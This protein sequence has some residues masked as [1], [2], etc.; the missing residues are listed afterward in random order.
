M[1]KQLIT[2]DSRK[3]SGRAR[4]E[5]GFSL[6]QLLITAMVMILVGAFALM[7][8]AS[9]RA[10]MRLAS[11]ARQ[12]AAYV[13]K[14]RIDAV[15]RH[16][17]SASPTKIE[18]VDTN[19]YRVTMDFD[20]SGI[21]TARTFDFKDGVSLLSLS[22]QPITFDWRGRMASCTASFS[23]VSSQSGTSPVSVD[24]TASGDVTVDS[25][26]D[27]MPDTITYTNV[28]KTTDISSDATVKGTTAA[29]TFSATDCSALDAGSTA[30]VSG[31]GACGTISVNPGKISIKRNGGSNGSFTVTVTSSALITAGGTSN[32][33]FTPSS[34]NVSTT[35][36]SF[37]V[38][39][40]NR[41]TG[42][43]PVT[44]SSPCATASVVVRVTK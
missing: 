6:L 10:N 9:A 28:N 41:A 21:I 12:F 44:F 35:G 27:D 26:I 23:M 30:G 39:S 33:T 13:E 38:K 16:V 43:F 32:L 19:T 18:F 1:S 29:P 7:S 40:I 20:G 14:A 31:T 17:S 24:V 15:R 34:T 8:I 37:I 42:D 25:D 3:A 5:G 36:Y 22:P 2:G 4:L 11:S